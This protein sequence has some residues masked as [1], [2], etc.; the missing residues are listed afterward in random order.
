MPP[1]VDV[2]DVITLSCSYNIGKQKLNSV[3]WYK[4]DKEFY[5]WEMLKWARYRYTLCECMF[6]IFGCM[7]D[8]IQ[9]EKVSSCSFHYS[10]AFLLCYQLTA[11]MHIAYIFQRVERKK[12][13]TCILLQSDKLQTDLCYYIRWAAKHYTEIAVWSENMSYLIF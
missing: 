8:D 1:F 7:A 10:L 11:N 3:K 12:I 2:R 13:C 9:S 5:R 4:N 6:C